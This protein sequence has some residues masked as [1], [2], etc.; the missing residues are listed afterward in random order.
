MERRK[1]TVAH[2]ITAACIGAKH[3]ELS[4]T[5]VCPMDCIHGT[6]TDSMLFI[7]PDACIDCGAC[8]PTCPRAAIYPEQKVPEKWRHIIQINADYFKEKTK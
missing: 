6:A 8:V 2:V 7:D 1:H 3:K 4:C 5:E